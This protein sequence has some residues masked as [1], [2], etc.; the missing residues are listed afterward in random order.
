[1]KMVSI[2]YKKSEVN[3]WGVEGSGVGQVYKNFTQ[4]LGTEYRL[5]FIPVLYLTIVFIKNHCFPLHGH[6]DF[7]LRP[8]VFCMI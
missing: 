3:E 6:P 4:L 2:V 8:D 1:M 7:F 5:V